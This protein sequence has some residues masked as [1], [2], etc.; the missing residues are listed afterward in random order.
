[1]SAK[2]WRQLLGK[3]KN[4]DVPAEIFPLPDG[5]NADGSRQADR[6]KGA[7]AVPAGRDQYA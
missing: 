2:Y 4:T 5:C 6:T 3:T 7:P 1:M